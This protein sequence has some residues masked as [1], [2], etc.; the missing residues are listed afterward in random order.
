MSPV[1]DAGNGAGSGPPKQD[2]RASRTPAMLELSSLAARLFEGLTVLVVGLIGIWLTFITFDLTPLDEY[3]RVAWL[4]AVVYALIGELTGCYDVDARF[5]LRYGWTRVLTAWVGSCVAMLTLAFFL[6]A[7]EGFSRGWAVFWF[8]SVALSLVV[9][10]GLTTVGLRSLKRRG[11]FNERVAILGAN[12]QGRRLASYIRSNSVLTVD[13]VGC[14]DDRATGD[15]GGCIP[16]RGGVEQLLTD[17]RAERIDQVIVAMPF[18]S[19]EELQDVVGRLA[20]LPVLIRLAPDLSSF[21]M[22]GQSMVMLG[23]LPLMTLFERPIN[24]VDQVIKR[25]EDLLLGS[26][27]L[28]LAAPFLA[29]VALAIKLDS[30]GPVFFKQ[31]R[32]GFNHRRFRIWKFRSMRSDTLQYDE[33]KQAQVSDPRVTRVGRIIRA[34]SIDEIPQL[35]N[36]VIGNMS[37]VG[38]RPHAPSTRVAGVLFSEATQKYAARHRVKPGMTGWAQVNGWRGETDTDEKLLKRVEFD[39]FYIDHWSVGFDL[40][41]MARTVAAVLFPKSAY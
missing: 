13:I 35:F 40:Y 22:A 16:M 37:L 32:E 24:D 5:S 20:M 8:V 3:V 23:D 6:K 19:D 18:A 33:I 10:R 2:R 29:I 12:T 41:I 1:T 28:I 27:V 17:I 21:T 31:E 26:I 36:V 30:P 25:V 4:S 14:Y 11:I 7:S 15:D 39:L 9:V 34:T 38:P